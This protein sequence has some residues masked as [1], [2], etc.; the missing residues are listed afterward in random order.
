MTSLDP[1]SDVVVGPGSCLEARG[2]V[3]TRIDGPTSSSKKS[4]AS[5]WR[6]YRSLPGVLRRAFERV[7][8]VRRLKRRVVG[9][10][11]E[12]VLRLVEH[13]EASGLP[14]WLAGGW[15]VDALAGRQ[16][17]WHH[18]LDLVVRIEDEESVAACLAS[19]GFEPYAQFEVPE[20]GLS[21]S[22]VYRDTIGR[23]VDVHPVTIVGPGTESD[24]TPALGWDCFCW[25][26]VA[27]RIVPCLSIDVQL[28]LHR[29]YEPRGRDLQDLAT[30]RSIAPSDPR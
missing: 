5:A 6:I 25:G 26:S 13:F 22:S 19:L 10:R 9:V 7:R 4:S 23:H 20:A 24:L 12:Q 21:R 17:R 29:G 3:P 27:G 14:L 16:T 11:S 8:F 2:D 1:R 18:D 15:G 28:A 30:L